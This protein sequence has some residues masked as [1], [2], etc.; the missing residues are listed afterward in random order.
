[1]FR[2]LLIFV[3][4][5]VYGMASVGLLG[6]SWT[7]FHKTSFQYLVKEGAFS[8]LTTF[9]FTSEQ[10][11]TLQWME[12]GRE[13][14]LDGKMFDVSE[15]ERV[16]DN[17]LVKCKHDVIES[18]VRDFFDDE[19]GDVGDHGKPKKKDGQNKNR[20]SKFFPGQKTAYEPEFLLFQPLTYSQ[21]SEYSTTTLREVESPPPE[22]VLS[23]TV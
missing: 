13:F 14:K 20:V 19:Q 10:F 18:V 16:G 5:T 8:N 3:T 11:E 4:L 6:T 12:E 15:I 7:L 23:P 22:Q 1:M 21:L 2:R 17:Y 9:T